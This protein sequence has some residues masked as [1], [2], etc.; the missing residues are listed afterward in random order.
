MNTRPNIPGTYNSLSFD[1]GGKEVYEMQLFD[2]PD[3]GTIADIAKLYEWAEENHY[4][5]EYRASDRTFIASPR[6]GPQYSRFNEH[7]QL[8]FEDW[9]YEAYAGDTQLGY[10]EWV[11]HNIHTLDE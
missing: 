4:R 3:F 1:E 11:D 2:S 9:K 8:P 7:P 6:P 5:I 10:A